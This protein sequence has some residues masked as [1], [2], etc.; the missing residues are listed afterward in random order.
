MKNKYILLLVLVLVATTVLA[1]C[2]SGG[3]KGEENGTGTANTA[4]PET[5]KD[6]KK[7]GELSEEDL[8][9]PPGT[10][11]I[12]KE[13]V[14][15]KAM[16]RGNPLVE[17][18]ATN[19]FTKWYEEKTNVHIEWEVVPEQ[20]R[21]EKL[22]LALTGNDYPDI[23]FGINVSSTQQ[24]I[25][26][27]Q[28]IFLPL[29]DLIEK[30]GTQVKKMFE[31]KPF[32]KN[33]ITAPDGN[34]YGLPDVN[35]CFHCSMAQKMWLNKEWLDKLELQM[36]ATTEEL[37]E[38]LKA[39]KEKDPN[40]NNKQDEIPLAFTQKS[41]LSNMEAFLMNSFVYT[42]MINSTTKYLYADADNKVNASFEQ[43]GWKEGLKYL[44]RLYSEGLIAQESF[45]QDGNQLIQL[46]ENSDEVILG[47]AGGGHQGVFTVLHGDSGRWMNYSAVP[48]LKGPEGVQYASYDPT[49]MTAGA[50][51]ITDKAKYP[52][53]ALR[54]ADGLYEFE[55][56]LR[57]NHGR[58]GVEWR[59]AEPGELG[60]N[61]EQA[62]WAEIEFHGTLQN[63]N[64]SQTGPGRRSN[65]FR[66]SSVAK[67]DTD[68]EVILYKET[69]E[70][71]EPYQPKDV[72]SLPPLFL[73]EEQA[74]EAADLQK[75]LF[76]Y[77]EEMTARFVIGDA[78]IEKE[79]ENYLKT[80]KDMNLARYID[81]YQEAY[82]PH[83][84]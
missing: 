3:N 10:Y 42:P 7:S 12:T 36:P 75:T 63:N 23:I 9:T 11:P 82:Q 19:D 72:K 24:M 71:Y 64:Y 83:T 53:I 13:K 34:I 77:V 35:E 58:P 28:G 66:L 4:K 78:D 15:I 22:N 30:Q 61:G 73:T 29:N 27:S 62:T 32:V 69:K 31:D 26:G 81:I 50:F 60:I 76:D 49:G 80:L 43:P 25:Y 16:V 38:V 84:N 56:T 48:P 17:D 45:T 5:K 8:L 55:H 70:K 2:G 40:G 21:Q 46:G 54:W 51:I 79:W 74:A 68:S 37:Y 18:F 39:F 57:S 6:N 65:E 44:N 33:T 41:W 47:G 59:E 14:T 1:A 20:S 52:E 67:G